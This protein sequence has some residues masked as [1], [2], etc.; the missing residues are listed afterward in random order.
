[1]VVFNAQNRT[2]EVGIRKV[3]GASSFNLTL[4]LT[5]DYLKLIL[6]GSA[7]SIPISYMLFTVIIAQQ[8]AYSTGIG[9]LPIVLSLLVILIL[10]L[11]TVITETWKVSNLNPT[12]TLRSE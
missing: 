9:I 7:I 2:K 8:N 10:G 12:D 1:M 4:L 3:M 6:I 5:K 11:S